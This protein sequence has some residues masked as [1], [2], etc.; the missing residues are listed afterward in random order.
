MI[1]F[2]IEEKQVVAE[3]NIVIDEYNKHDTSTSVLWK[4]KTIKFGDKKQI[5]RIHDT[6][7]HFQSL[8]F[9]EEC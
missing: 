7:A 2:V 8:P 6:D 4:K 1:G 5:K 9:L 3:A